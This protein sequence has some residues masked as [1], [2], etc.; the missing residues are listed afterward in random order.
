[1][2]GFRRL[3]LVAFPILILPFIGL[4][5]STV[6]NEV[7]GLKVVPKEGA[8]RLEISK[9]GD[10]TFSSFTMSEPDRLVIN[11]IGAKYDI[12]WGVQQITSPLAYRVRTSQFQV[13]PVMITRVVLDLKKEVNYKIWE[14][15]DVQIIEVA[16]RS[17]ASYAEAGEIEQAPPPP[18][19]PLTEQSPAPTGEGT[20][21]EDIEATMG[22]VLPL[23]VPIDSEKAVT[24]EKKESPPVKEKKESPPV[25]EKKETPDAEKTEEVQPQVAPSPWVDEKK[26]SEREVPQT[27]SV[28]EVSLG[29]ELI[30]REEP[31]PIPPV[32]EPVPWVDSYVRGAPAGGG[33]LGM[34]S[35]KITLDAQG[36]D[37]KTVLRSISDFAGIN[38]VAGPDVKGEVFVHIKD[39]PWEEALDILLRAHGYGYREEYGMIR[40]AELTRLMREELELQTADRK[41][42]D[43]LPLKTRII[44]VHNSNAE[45]LQSALQNVVSQRGKIDVDLGSNALII[46]DI[47]KNIEKIAVM[48]TDLDKK[49]HQVDINA[50]LVEV[51]V[52]ATRELGINWGLMNLHKSGFSGVGSAEVDAGIPLSSGTLKFGTVRSWGELN[53]IL[54]MLEKS[55]KANI[56]SNP[57]ITTMD[58]REASILVGKEI[59]LIVADEAG[60]PITELTK[61]GIMLKV[62]PHVNADRT[63]TLDLHPEVSDLQSESTA[64]GGVIIS[65]SEADT[66]VIV[67]NGETAVIGGLIK[68]LESNVKQGIPVLKDIPYL[69]SLFSSTTTANKKQELVIF[70]TPTIVE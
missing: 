38:I 44:F 43:L 56:I 34:G 29:E 6:V 48:I 68:K 23:I 40:V 5:A 32:K 2:F 37:I 51:D 65:T 31:S 52:E 50:K 20:E 64:Q 28:T 36:A 57:R 9:V 11:C 33:G 24:S 30:L 7:N 18:D 17:P 15:G 39:E 49:T 55:N 60:N 27:E 69:G 25:D 3:A 45:E 10:V 66:R 70:V 14:E 35:R 16:E 59:P 1:M 13:D 8:L 22:P 41:K 67:N 53:V 63:I 47:E 19:Q 58:N 4:S 21:E 62:I 26:T 54:E 46:N 42:E 61:I 12:P